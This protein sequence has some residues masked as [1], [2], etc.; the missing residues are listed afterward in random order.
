M[1]TLG[2]AIV[3]RNRLIAASDL[4]DNI[5]DENQRKAML[6]AV[7]AGGGFAGAETVGAV[8]DLLREAPATMVRMWS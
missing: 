8:N 6:T 2:D 1:K 7:V 4:A 5:S 3:L